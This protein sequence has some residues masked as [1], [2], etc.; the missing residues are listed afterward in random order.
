[1]DP[2]AVSRQIQEHEASTAQRR[3]TLVADAERKRTAL[4]TLTAASCYEDHR[5][6]AIK[7][8]QLVADATRCVQGVQ[9]ADREV[10]TLLLAQRSL[11][12]SLQ[13]LQQGRAFV[14]SMSARIERIV[15]D[16][17]VAMDRL[18]EEEAR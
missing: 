12:E 17:G 2:T 8:Q 15:G 13:G 14:E 7:H 11:D 6:M 4:C 10:K 16:L 18:R 9:A 3:K 1:M 5:E